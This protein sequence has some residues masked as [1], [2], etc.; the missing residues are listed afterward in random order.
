MRV[1]ERSH[2]GNPVK[3]LG[4]SLDL[5][6]VGIRGG[7]EVGELSLI[8]VLLAELAK[9]LSEVDTLLT[10]NL[11]GRGV[12]RSGTVTDGV[13][14]LG[15]EK[16]QVV[17]NEKTTSLSLRVRE[18]AHQVTGDV[19]RSVTGSPDEETVWD[20][21][22]L[23]VGVLDDNRL[24]LDVL[25]HGSGKDINSVGS[26]LV[27]GVLDQLLAEGGKDVGQSLNKSDLQSVGDLR[28]PLAQVVLHVRWCIK[29][30]RSHSQSRNRGALRRT[31]HR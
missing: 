5:S 27:L 19:S 17:V 31:Q 7:L 23:L 30:Q 29:K 2:L 26:E 13:S 8:L 18:L 21:A 6:G 25:D 22:H 14:A 11:G 28:V 20:L 12:L 10:G 16:G 4:Q 9:G 24:R 1:V 15:A 3:L